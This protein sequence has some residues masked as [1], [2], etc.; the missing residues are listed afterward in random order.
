[1]EDYKQ[2][3]SKNLNN[4]KED[5]SAYGNEGDLWKLAGDIKNTPG[6]LCLH[7]CGNLKHNIGA[8]IGKNGYVR[9]RDSEF[10]RKNVPKSELLKEVDNT[11]EMIS[12]VLSKLTD[13]DMKVEFPADA[14]SQGGTI[15]LIILRVAAHMGYHLGQ[16]NYH[17]RLI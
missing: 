6:N 15:A 1:M 3:F 7:I 12:P 10:A 13:D 9:N 4:L 11:I 5:I 14:F 17:R 2:F 8:I 16:I